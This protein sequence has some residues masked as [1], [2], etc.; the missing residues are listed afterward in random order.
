MR[1]I[2]SLNSTVSATFG[3]IVRS[4]PTTGDFQG[5]VGGIYTVGMNTAFIRTYQ[6]V[7]SKNSFDP[8]TSWHT[9][10]VE[11]KG[12]TISFFID[13]TQGSSPLLTVEDNQY[14]SGGQ[15][16]LMCSLIQLDISS[17]KVIAL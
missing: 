17:F 12:T 13:P 3:I 10:R 15:I 5:Y 14:L 4:V 7:L 9:Y 1:V 16:G 8:G 6:A 2:S 11:V